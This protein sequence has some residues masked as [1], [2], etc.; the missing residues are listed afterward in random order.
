MGCRKWTKQLE[1]SWGRTRNWCWQFWGILCG[2]G[3]LKDAFFKT[4]SPHRNSIHGCLS[5]G[6]TDHNDLLFFDLLWK[7][8]LGFYALYKLSLNTHRR[9]HNKRNA[10]LECAWR[11]QISMHFGIPYGQVTNVYVFSQKTGFIELETRLARNANLR[12]KSVVQS[13]LDDLT[14]HI[15]I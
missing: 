9:N 4:E 12:N 15:F 14:M 2:K 5:N 7:T 11:G 13:E 10:F 1:S 8:T 6:E 3:Y